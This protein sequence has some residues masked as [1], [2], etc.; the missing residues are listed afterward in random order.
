MMKKAF[1]QYT[2]LFAAVV[3]IGLAMLYT[4]G[5]LPQEKVHHN[6][7]LSAA[8]F[9]AEGDYPWILNSWNETYKL[10]AF[11]E[12][13]IVNHAYYMDTRE[14]PL[15]VI[16]NLHFRNGKHP[17]QCLLELAERPDAPGNSDRARY[18]LGFRAYVRPLLSVMPYQDIRGVISI[19]FFSLLTAAVLALRSHAGTASAVCLALSVIA[20]NPVIVSTSLQYSICFLIAFVGVWLVCR[21]EWNNRSLGGLFMVLGQATMFFDFYTS[22]LI[23]W[24]MPLV[25][26]MSIQRVQRKTDSKQ[27]LKQLGFTLL[28]WVIGYAGM[29]VLKM[30]LNT[31]LTEKNGFEVL[32]QFLYYTGFSEIPENVEVF[33]PWQ[34]LF[35][36]LK[37]VLTVQNRFMLCV[38]GIPALAVYY[39]RM[40]RRGSVRLADRGIWVYALAAF[41]PVLWLFCSRQASGVHAYFQYRTLA[42]AVYAGLCFVMQLLEPVPKKAS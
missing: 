8:Q 32:K 19:V 24:G 9:E 5:L 27:M 3:L 42:A 22:P 2:A 29:W 35:V 33:T 6:I 40:K 41:V 36:C 21:C 25:A 26:L 4:V 20:M 15:S 1:I 38:A 14:S 39:V 13:L 10:D 34:A 7:A 12:S 28:M 11:S 16:E 37:K 18:W 23:T 30:I 17:V 31:L